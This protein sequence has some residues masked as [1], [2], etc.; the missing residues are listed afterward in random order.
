MAQMNVTGGKYENFFM[1]QDRRKSRTFD[2]A[3]DLV[4]TTLDPPLLYLDPSGSGRNVDL[5]AVGDSEGLCFTIVNTADGAEILTIRDS[6]GSGLTPA[7]TP[8]ENETAILHCDGT[9]W[10]GY[11]AIGA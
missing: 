11:V 2:M 6:A 3:A 7:I 1:A 10:R 4:L 9:T 8:T 5:P